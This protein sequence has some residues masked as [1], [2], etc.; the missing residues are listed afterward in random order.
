MNTGIAV[1]HTLMGFISDIWKAIFMEMKSGIFM[2]LRNKKKKKKRGE[3][4]YFW[5]DQKIDEYKY[6]LLWLLNRKSRI[7]GLL[8][9]IEAFLEKLIV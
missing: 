6:I 5:V 7:S 2:N 4:F 9:K 8:Q 3:W 1:I